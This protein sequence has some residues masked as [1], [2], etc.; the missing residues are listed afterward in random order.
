MLFDYSYNG[1]SNISGT[2][3]ST[4]M[5]FVPDA[6]R[7]PTF[8]IAELRQK[9]EFREAI[10]ALHDVVISDLRF[11]PKDKTAYKEWAASREQ[12]D[13]QEVAA[14]RAD[15]QA[16]IKP[17]QDE[18]SELYKQR[19]SRWNPFYEAR[20][21]YY[22]YL[23]ERDKDL[24]FV[25]DPVISVHPDEVFFECFSEDESSYGRLG[26]NYEVFQNVKEFECGT[27]NIDYSDSLY[28]EFQKIRT[29]KTTKFEIDP[30]GFEVKTTHENSFK[31][32]KIDL[33][34]SWVR[35]FLQVSSAMSLPTTSFD[36]HPLDVHNIC[37]VL[38]RRKEKES[39]RSMRYV[40]KPNEPIKIIFEPWNIEITCAR[41]I[42]HGTEA[43]D[44]R[45][46]GRRRLLILERLI[47]IAKKFTVH[48]LGTGLPS[49]YIA[50]LGDLNFT[51]GL[52]GWT[53]N[54][55]SKAGNF[56]LL[57]PRADV[58]N[59][60][61]QFV[62]N[63]LKTNWEEKPDALAKRLNLDKSVVLGALGAYTQAGRAIYDLNKGVYRV[64]ELTRDPLPMD[65]LRF[66]NEREE[67]ATR[68]LVK[69]AVTFSQREAKQDGNFILAGTVKDK[70]KTY[71]VSMMI[72]S[73][74]R[75]TNPKC[76]CNFF[77]MNKMFKGPC[78]HLLALRMANS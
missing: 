28:K 15:V 61:K 18:L 46:W 37:F 75:M 54:D 43:Q 55:W 29:Y 65:K 40:L 52:S 62:F 48:L 51:L 77:L 17:L 63:S 14:K 31:E 13:W 19:N 8:F 44:I 68:F 58:D 42:Y 27:T 71:D 64:R 33:P 56:D 2:S 9:L 35:G 38:R 24:W 60:T 3:S 20:S 12:I 23:Y 70:E 21:R 34:D 4:S 67:A 1:S 66:A 47:P 45:V 49:F 10:S 6:T 26:A 5:N 76:T 72:D 73:D 57:A 32:V 16:K 39:P 41:S 69:K 25:L 78:E 53:A 50:D 7:E 36:L 30:S 74:Q 59:T 11:K 22:K